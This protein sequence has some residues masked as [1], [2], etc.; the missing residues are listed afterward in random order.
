MNTTPQPTEGVLSGVR[1]LDFTWFVAG[2]WGPRMLTPYGAEV[3]H[4]EPPHQPDKYRFDFRRV[5]S[6]SSDK[7]MRDGESS[8]PYYTSPDFGHLHSGKLA[9]NLNTRHPEGIRLLERLV[10]MSDALCENFSGGVLESWGMGWDRMHE[11]NPRLVY[12]S[13]TGFGHEGEWGK[14]RTLGASVQ[15]QSGLT[16]TSGLPDEAP[17]GWGYAHMDVMGG[18][19]GGLGLMM[20]LMQA[21]RTGKG[22]VIDYAITEA[23][24]FLLGPYFLDYQVNGRPTRR[25]GF[26]PGNRSEWPAVAPHNAYRCAGIDRQGQDWWVFIACETQ[27]QFE[28]LCAVMNKPELIYDPRFATIQ[29]RIEHQDELDD[30]ISGWTAP[31]RRYEIMEM[32][33]HAGIIGAA[34]QE[35][36][37]RVEYDPQLRARGIYPV[38][39]HPEVGDFQHEAFP[40]RVNGSLNESGRGPMLA[41]HTEYVFGELLGLNTSQID[42]LRHDGVI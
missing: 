30:V 29:A 33:Q 13:S 37:D 3:I 23:G 40:P 38:I 19:T 5:N 27:E 20:G 18:W 14:F 22:M 21:K 28:S 31:R 32:L 6:A 4:I 42:T 17:A 39:S 34:V 24:M 35:T 11:L 15:A 26:P 2:P 25:L 36:E 41:E 8:P 9:I 1:V 12:L 10:T 7:E 16:V